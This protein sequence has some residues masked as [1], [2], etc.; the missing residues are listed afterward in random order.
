[1]ESESLRVRNYA[2]TDLSHVMEEFCVSFTTMQPQG[3]A[4][5]RQIW[6]N[7]LDR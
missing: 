1:V 7:L 6:R 4:D 5:R 3:H 2:H